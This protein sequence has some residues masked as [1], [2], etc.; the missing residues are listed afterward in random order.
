[1]SPVSR[2][3]LIL[4]LLM[5]ILLIGVA[6]GRLWQSHALDRA[7]TPQQIVAALPKETRD[8]F[9]KTLAKTTDDVAPLR[10]E[11]ISNRRAAMCILSRQPFDKKAYAARIEALHPLH[12]QMMRRITA[13]VSAVAKDL[14]PS[15]RFAFVDMLRP[16]PPSH[17][18]TD[19][20]GPAEDDKR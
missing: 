13:A 12:G 17:E 2:R 4:S 3:V 7:A 9:D 20:C 10:A 11:I 6:I 19:S 18:L 1:M 8:L 5:N 14:P 15:A 16:V